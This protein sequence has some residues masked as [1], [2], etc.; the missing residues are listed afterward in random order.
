MGRHRALREVPRPRA[1]VRGENDENTSS[2]FVSTLSL[3]W[4]LDDKDVVTGVHLTRN[5]EGSVPPRGWKM[6]RLNQPARL[7][8]QT[9]F[10]TASASSGPGRRWKDVGLP[11]FLSDLQASGTALSWQLPQLCRVDPRRSGSRSQAGTSTD[12]PRMLSRWR[13]LL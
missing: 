6:P 4:Q 7:W 1:E 11:G 9:C 8:P 12:G 10:R 5:T 13:T 2:S 3:Q